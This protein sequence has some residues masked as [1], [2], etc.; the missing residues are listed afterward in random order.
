MP[1]ALEQNDARTGERHPL[2]LR[3]VLHTDGASAEGEV[4]DLSRDGAKFRSNGDW[5]VGKEVR[6]TMEMFGS[7][8]GHVVWSQDGA[9]GIR[10]AEEFI[11]LTLLVGGWCSLGA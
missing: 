2:C 3:A 1:H 6:V 8:R 5:S 10:F 7:C 11:M 4:V 9:I